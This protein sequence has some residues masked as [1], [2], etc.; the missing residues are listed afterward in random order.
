MPFLVIATDDGYLDTAVSTPNLIIGPGERYEV[1][2]DFTGLARG[3][4]NVILKN[5]A[6]TPF[7]GGAKVVRGT[8]DTVMQF[9]VVANTRHCPM[10]RSRQGRISVRLNPIVNIKARRRPLIRSG[11]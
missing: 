10:Q 4:R 2:V 1:I 11:S 3:V 7:P 9:R 5:S 6:R 8:T